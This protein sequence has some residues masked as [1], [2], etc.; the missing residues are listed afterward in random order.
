M[1]VKVPELKFDPALDDETPVELNKRQREKAAKS[2]QEI[3]TVIAFL[4][5][6]LKDNELKVAT[7]KSTLSCLQNYYVDLCKAL[8]FQSN[9]RFEQEE[10]SKVIKNLRAELDELKKSVGEETSTVGVSSAL[11]LWTRN[12]E[13]F[14]RNK[15]LGHVAS[16][17]HKDA[18]FLSRYGG[19]AFHATISLFIDPEMLKDHIFEEITPEE[20]NEIT[21][22]IKHL[23]D[24]LN[25]YEKS[26]GR[27]LN[28]LDTD[29]NKTFI[30]E[31]LQR[32]YPSLN[33]WEW[34][35]RGSHPRL[36][37]SVLESCEI[38]IDDL[39]DLAK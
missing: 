24:N 30:T 18:R 35:I 33:V 21:K 6:L 29:H 10:R 17:D 34:R 36:G 9:S 7:R 11:Q 15:G 26:A 28:L 5:D 19:T 38:H 32:K 20:E 14:I 12:F 3:H 13:R 37:P 4:S 23:L 22:N 2:L 25:V 31:F 16:Y 1:K 27:R 8:D 39:D